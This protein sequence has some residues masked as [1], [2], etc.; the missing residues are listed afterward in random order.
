MLPPMD[1]YHYTCREYLPNIAR[2]GR[3]RGEVP[4]T[5][6]KVIQAVWLTT[7]PNPEGHGLSDGDEVIAPKLF[8]LPPGAKL[9]FPN[10]RA[11]RFKVIIPE[12]GGELVRWSEWGRRRL[13]PQ[14]YR[15][16]NLIGGGKAGTWYVYF[17]VIAPSYLDPFD[18]VAGTPLPDWPSAYLD[19]P[20]AKYRELPAN[21]LMIATPAYD[22]KGSLPLEDIEDWLLHR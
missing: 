10:K 3:R 17:G 7:D 19:L 8:G 1:Y 18:L 6:C 15:K 2:E 20:P 13:T 5:K 4:L 9:R 16:L 12:T 21:K 14:W 22:A 11:I